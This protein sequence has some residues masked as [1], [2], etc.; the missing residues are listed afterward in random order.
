MSTGTE[1]GLTRTKQSQSVYKHHVL[2]QYV[3]PY[4]AKTASVC[5]P[6]RCVVV[7]GFA[8]RGRYEDGSPGSADTLMIEAQKLKNRSQVDVFL[9]EK[10][11]S[12]FA[13]LDTIADEF[14]GRGQVVQTR[15]GECADYLDEIVAFARGASLFLFLDPCG[16]NLPFDELARVLAG[17]RRG[18]YPATE[19]L[20]NI[21]ADAIRRCGGLVLAKGEDANTD[22][23]DTMCGGQWWRDVA[24]KAYENS[25]RR[26]WESA[27]HAVVGEYARRLAEQCGAGYVVAPVHRKEG[28]QPVYFLVFLTRNHQGFWLFGNAAAKARYAWLTFLEERTI[29]ID[30]M[31]PMITVADQ[32]KMDRAAAASTIRTNIEKMIAGGVRQFVPA[33]KVLEVFGDLYGEVEERVAHQVLREMVA[34]HTLRVATRKAQQYASTYAVVS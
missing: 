14:R 21:N 1:A 22:A 9:V 7:D 28:H 23:V 2:K 11:R 5:T 25:G 27:A 32:Q 17:G 26:N 33:E 4:A 24:I 6:R 16:V 15:N 20:L 3:L 18:R 29:Q 31:Q 19:A 10:D 13:Q 8:G 12:D 30:G 34:D